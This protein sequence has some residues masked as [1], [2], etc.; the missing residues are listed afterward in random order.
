MAHSLKDIY[1]KILSINQNIEQTK[2]PLGRYC[3]RFMPIINTCKAHLDDIENDYKYFLFCN[4]KSNRLSIESIRIP[5][6][7]KISNKLLDT[8]NKKNKE[9]LSTLKTEL[10]SLFKHSSLMVFDLPN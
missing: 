3:Q 8:M 9:Y 10:L 4:L 5:F 7:I 6:I 1:F 2:K